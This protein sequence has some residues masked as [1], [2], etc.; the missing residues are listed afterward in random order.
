MKCGIELIFD[1]ES[2]NKINSIRKKLVEAGVHD[3]AVKLNHVSL[4]GVEFRED[5]LDLVKQITQNFACTHAALNLTLSALGAFMGATNVVFYAPVLTDELVRY[6]D[7]LVAE[8]T[9]NGM[10]C[11][12]NYTHNNWLPHC[13][14]AIRISDA[15][16]KIAMD[17]LKDNKILPINVVGT[18][19]DVLLSDPKP[20]KQL[21][22]YD[23][24]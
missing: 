13:T 24:N 7:E 17:V 19:V 2:Q 16:F 23:L 22:V 15:E 10:V 11:D 3:E 9:K 6:N 1:D 8:F 14:L 21:A 5:Q 18:K 20:Y 12:K 4:T